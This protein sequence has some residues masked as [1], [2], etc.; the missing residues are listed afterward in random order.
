MGNDVSLLRWVSGTYRAA[1]ERTGRYREHHVQGKAPV[2]ITCKL[3]DLEWLEYYAQIDPT[4][5]NP[6]DTDASKVLR[7]LKIYRFTRRVPKSA[8]HMPFCGHCL[9]KL[10]KAQ[11]AVW[12]VC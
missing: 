10:L 9:A 7:R 2:L 8:A 1:S 6:W 12:G 11:G 3:S 4:T 5:G